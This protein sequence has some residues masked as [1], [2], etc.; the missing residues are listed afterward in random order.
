CPPPE[1][2]ASTA[3]SGCWTGPQRPRPAPGSG[4]FARACSRWLLS[5][6]L[7]GSLDAGQ[8]FG[9]DRLRIG[10]AAALF[11]LRQVA[12]VTLRTRRSGRIVFILARGE[13]ATGAVPQ[14]WRR[15]I[16]SERR[17]RGV[18]TGAPVGH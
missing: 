10:G 9:E 14:G 16:G 2:T 7:P 8:G 1:C 17:R 5:P 18:P 6:G 4:L 11:P 3:P 15:D 12:L 13:P